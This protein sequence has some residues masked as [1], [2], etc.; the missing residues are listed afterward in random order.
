MCELGGRGC[1]GG[2]GACVCDKEGRGDINPT[3]LNHRQQ[4]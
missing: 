4:I 3:H 2:G 1:V